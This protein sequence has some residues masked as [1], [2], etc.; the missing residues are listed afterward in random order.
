MD[1]KVKEHIICR[2]IHHSRPD[3]ECLYVKREND[4]K[5][6]IQRELTNKATTI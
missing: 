6:L 5:R 2:R 3:I 4:G 1:S